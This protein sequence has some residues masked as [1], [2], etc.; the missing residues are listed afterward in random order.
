MPASGALNNVFHS[1][2]KLTSKKRIA[3]GTG[4]VELPCVELK[5]RVNAV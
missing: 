2:K 3:G 1:D 5:R 4:L